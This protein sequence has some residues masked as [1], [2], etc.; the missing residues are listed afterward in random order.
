M[1]HLPQDET[2]AIARLPG[3]D[4]EIRHTPP[5]PGSGERLS[6]TLEA[7]PALGRLDAAAPLL[8]WT[9]LAQAAWTPW[10]ALAEAMRPRLPPPRG[11]EG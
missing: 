4:I 10:L 8:F 9:M 11:T 5:G 1:T 2:R 3:L 6:V 7:A